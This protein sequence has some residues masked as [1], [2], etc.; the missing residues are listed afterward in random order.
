MADKIERAGAT[1]VLI[2]N[3]STEQARDF[4]RET[5]TSLQLLVDP[6]LEGYRAASLERRLLAPYSPRGWLAA[7]RSMLRG[8]RPSRPAG[9][10]YQLGGTFVVTPEQRVAYAFVSKDMHTPAPI[11]D[12]LSAL[13]RLQDR[14][15][16][17]EMRSA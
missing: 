10:I 15:A 14:E 13:R 7:L 9:D 4:L 12:V 11:N 16:A 5:E 1:L 8:F 3:G 6:N 17:Y 2:G